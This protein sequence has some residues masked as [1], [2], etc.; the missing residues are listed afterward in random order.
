MDPL[1]ALDQKKLQTAAQLDAAN[2]Y[3]R[4]EELDEPPDD[5]LA[6][7][8]PAAAREP[9]LLKNARA[10]GPRRCA[11]LDL[12]S[13]PSQLSQSDWAVSE[14]ELRRRAQRLAD[15]GAKQYPPDDRNARSIELP[16][17]CQA[18]IVM[19]VD[20]ALVAED[21]A[22]VE[23]TWIE[24][25][26]FKGRVKTTARACRAEETERV[27]ALG[28]SPYIVFHKLEGKSMPLLSA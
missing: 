21:G 27:L 14:E 23:C 2:F 22:P 5:P 9:T 28:K 25:G 24:G 20:A 10:L 16:L 18:G 17:V 19:Q 12:S 4:L 3:Q 13:P 11:L 7:A 1:D 8:L 15:L 26:T 6:T